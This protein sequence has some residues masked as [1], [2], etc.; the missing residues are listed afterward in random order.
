MSV[1]L[2]MSP[3]FGATSLVSFDLR[4]PAKRNDRPANSPNPSSHSPHVTSTDA[5]DEGRDDDETQS[6]GSGKRRRLTTTDFTRRKRAVTACQFCRTRKTKCDNV[7]PRCGYCVHQK[8]RCVYGDTEGDDGSEAGVSNR[9]IMDRLDEIKDMLQSNDRVPLQV[10]NAEPSSL[11]VDESQHAPLVSSPWARFS[12]NT[13]YQ[14]PV[15]AAQ[16]SGKRPERFLFAALRCESLLRWPVLRHVVP[17]YAHD[18]DSF[19]LS[20]AYKE[21]SFQAQG[22]KGISEDSFVPLCRKFL[23][24]VHPR[25]PILHG[26]E[27]LRHAREME[28][29]GLKWDSA[30]CL[31]LLA[32]ALAAYSE[33]WVKPNE[34]PIPPNQE[35]FEDLYDSDQQSMAEPYYA[36]AQKRMG[37]LGNTIQDIQCYFF[38]SVFEKCALRPMKAWYN[39]QQACSRLETH[40]LQRG[41]R[42]WATFRE[43]NPKDYHLEQRLF[44]SCFRAESE[45]VFELGLKPS[46]L[47]NF[48][49]PDPLPSPPEG[50][51]T[52][53]TPRTHDSPIDADEK[54]RQLD[55]RG[56][57]FYLS[58]ISIRRTIDETLHLLYRH[59]EEYWMKNPAQLIRQHHECEQQVSLWHYHLPSI[60]QFDY[61]ALPDEQFATALQGR[62]FLWLEYTLRPILYYVLHKQSDEPVSPEA[63]TLASRELS[64]CATVIHRLSFHRRHGGTWFIS[65]KAFTCAC[66]ILTAVLNPHRVQPPEAWR[67]ITEIAIQTLE[68]WA[69]DASDLRRMADILRHM[70]HETRVQRGEHAMAGLE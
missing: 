14:T 21:T 44:W 10:S 3:P 30:S 66:L 32:C 6:T 70:Y 60:V 41:E 8:A 23:A 54:Q 69:R 40:L 26:H 57:C 48:S 46:S 18:I 29:H 4:A 20:P 1:S 15:P 50:I 65:R 16:P 42:P 53:Q 22:N 27:L 33:M 68:R 59:G 52:D 11:A 62:A 2:D 67:T 56:W 43:E 34:Y 45:L 9:Q 35:Q 37:L 24:H 49:Y 17:S 31:V 5:A 47:E 58:E 25:N 28:E 7:R 36:A 64:M 63:Q 61:D 51:L 12:P 39:I 13:Q 19:P 55:E 38:A